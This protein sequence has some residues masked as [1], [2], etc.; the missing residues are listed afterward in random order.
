MRVP[1]ASFIDVDGHEQASIDPEVTLPPY[2]HGR[3][4]LSDLLGRL[5]LC[6]MLYEARRNAEQDQEEMTW[7]ERSIL[8]ADAHIA[9]RVARSDVAVLP[10]ERLRERFE[11]DDAAVHLLIAAAAP[12]IDLTMARRMRDASRADRPQPEVWL[13]LELLSFGQEDQRLLRSVLL[14]DSPLLRWRLLRLGPARGWTPDGPPLHSPVVVPERIIDLIENRTDF[15]P[16]A[17]E[18]VA[19]LHR[20]GA[21]LPATLRESLPR[22]LFREGGHTQPILLTGPAL[23]GKTTAVAAAA[24]TMGRPALAVDLEALAMTLSPGE[25][26]QDL[27]REA[28]L[29]DAVLVLRAGALALDQ[30]IDLRRSVVAVLRDAGLPVVLT[31]HG[32]EAVSFVRCLPGC[33]WM[34]L[35]LPSEEEQHSLWTQVLSPG[36]ARQSTIDIAALVR[37]YPL[38]PGDI[39]AAGSLAQTRA[40]QRSA[41]DISVRFDD[42]IEAVR[43]RL[44]HR[45]GDVAE[46]VTTRLTWDDLVLRDEVQ[47]RI[48]ELLTAVSCQHTVMRSW[49]FERKLA[50]GRSV[51]ALFSGPPGTGKTMVA[52]LIAKKLGLELFRVDL[53]RVVSKWVGETEKNL[54]RAFDEAKR[55]Q[56]ILLFDEADSLFA[57]RTEV[58]S[59]NDRYANLEVNYLLQRLEAY[60]GVVLLTT[61]A[62]STIDDAFKRRLRFRVE[63]PMPDAEERARLWRSMLPSGAPVDIDIN[64]DQLARRFEMAGGYIKNAVIRAAY[65]AAATPRKR[66]TQAIITRAATLEWEDMG[67]LST[68]AVR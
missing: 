20:G 11:L 12:G 6:F 65:L 8:A 57:K 48:T 42:L 44:I 55:S 25:L 15:S 54:G 60:D 4:H 40:T 53:S 14:P 59:A 64:F 38:T 16:R 49:G 66:I 7:I 46:L 39:L 41:Q 21:S 32:T 26:L 24:A 37:R 30:R 22:A 51:S 45:L 56:A 18:H 36:G 47:E 63:F 29:L 17:F 27:Q 9:A 5:A 50:Y 43:S 35:D 31:S 67:N 3:E 61:N 10:I 62:Q 23:S 68:G 33:Q 2:S 28:R 19:T 13:L 52:T 34:T 1:V 58:K